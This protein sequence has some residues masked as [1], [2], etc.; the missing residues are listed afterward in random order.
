MLSFE[1]EQLGDKIAHLTL[2]E[3]E[4]LRKYLLKMYGI[5]PI[6]I[7]KIPVVWAGYEN[8]DVILEGYPQ[9]RKIA[10]IKE[11]RA[12]LGLGL[13]EAKEL[14]ERCPAKVKEN[15]SQEDADKIKSVFTDA[16]AVVAIRKH[17]N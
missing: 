13:K 1:I 2:M 12:L 7:Q 11:I 6:E 8:Y 17:N 14:V 10:V 3:V 9:D 15:L 16:G 4:E 5:D